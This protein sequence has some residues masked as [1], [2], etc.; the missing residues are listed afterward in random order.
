MSKKYYL[1][2][3]TG[4][5]FEEMSLYELGAELLNQ[6]SAKFD[7]NVEFT[8][9]HKT[10]NGRWDEVG[11]GTFLMNQTDDKAQAEEWLVEQFAQEFIDCGMGEEWLNIPDSVR[12]YDEEG[13]KEELQWIKENSDA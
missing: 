13:Y 8:L 1:T 9:L 2:T 6:D 11:H 4:G 5:T 7:V 3:D 12:A 10:L